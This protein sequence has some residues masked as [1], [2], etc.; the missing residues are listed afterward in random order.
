M[1]GQK[2]YSTIWSARA[3]SDLG[4]PV[5]PRWIASDARVLLYK[6][7]TGGFG[8][9]E[10][11]CGT[12]RISCLRPSSTP[13]GKTLKVIADPRTHPSDLKSLG[14]PRDERAGGCGPIHVRFFGC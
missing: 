5:R 8:L 12:R 7:K 14:F 10:N 9:N 3:C 13:W 6:V 1:R 4:A 2:T 11:L